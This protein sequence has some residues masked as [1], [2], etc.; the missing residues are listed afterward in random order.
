MRNTPL[1]VGIII[2]ILIGVGVYALSNNTIDTTDTN[3]NA[4][5]T[6]QMP[7]P[8]EE[9][10]TGATSTGTS[11][12]STTVTSNAATVSIKNFAYAPA[13]LNIKKGTKVTWT[14]GDTAPHTVTSES[15]DVLDSPTLSTGQSFSYTFTKAGTYAYYCTIHPNMKATV[16][17]TE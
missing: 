9:D 14:N 5:N 6:M 3:A 11:S 13:T 8:G 7:M 15:G 10:T 12:A 2:V 17:V 1:I 16:V 4:T